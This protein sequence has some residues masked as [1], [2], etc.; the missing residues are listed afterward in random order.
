MMRDPE[1]RERIRELLDSFA[2]DQAE[3]ERLKREADE[4]I[5]RLHQAVRE[6]RAAA[7]RSRV[8]LLCCRS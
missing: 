4:A 7:E 3:R 5:E 1:Q 6:L 2:G 8:K